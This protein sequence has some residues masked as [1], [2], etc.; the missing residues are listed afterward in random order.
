MEDLEV[1]LEDDV[2]EPTRVGPERHTLPKAVGA[3]HED[4]VGRGHVGDSRGR[5]LPAA[6]ILMNV[7]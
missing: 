1:S 4:C 2:A 7:P 3:A 5:T 6:T